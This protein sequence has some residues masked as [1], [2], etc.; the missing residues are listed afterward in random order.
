MRYGNLN[1]L[2]IVSKRKGKGKINANDYVDFIMDGKMF[3][4]WMESC[5]KLGQ[6]IMIEDGADYYNRVANMRKK[7]LEKDR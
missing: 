3:D 6:V 1:K 7:E 5:E 4:F 2:V